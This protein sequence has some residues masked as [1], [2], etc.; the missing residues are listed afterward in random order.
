MGK[1]IET[2]K[3]LNTTLHNL[4]K[5]QIVKITV[6]D[7]EQKSYTVPNDC[8]AHF[9]ITLLKPINT[10]DLTGAQA[11]ALLADP[12]RQTISRQTEE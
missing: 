10:D 1:D 5:D 8:D 4:N 3:T 12:K 2:R 11:K 6:D 9:A 7:V